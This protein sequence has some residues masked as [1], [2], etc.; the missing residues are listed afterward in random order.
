MSEFPRLQ[1]LATATCSHELF[2]SIAL[3]YQRENDKDIKHGKGLLN[4]Y[5]DL[6]HATKETQEFM[7]EVEGYRTFVGH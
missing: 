2:H 7:A 1:E 3:Y 5:V 6:V 4:C